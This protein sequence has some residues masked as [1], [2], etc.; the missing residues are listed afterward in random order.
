MRRRGRD[1]LSASEA[2]KETVEA[3]EFGIWVSILPHG[4]EE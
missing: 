4:D 1:P 2:R 3:R